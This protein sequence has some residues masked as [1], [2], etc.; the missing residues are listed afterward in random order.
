MKNNK[1]C[2]IERGRIYT[3]WILVCDLSLNCPCGF[4]FTTGISNNPLSIKRVK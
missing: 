4:P 3:R 1:L 2:I